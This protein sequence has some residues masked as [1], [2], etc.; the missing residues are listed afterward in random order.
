MINKE[1]SMVSAARIRDYQIKKAGSKKEAVAR[2]RAR[3]EVELEWRRAIRKVVDTYQ[4]AT[5][6]TIAALLGVNPSPQTP[7]DRT[8]L[9]QLYQRLERNAAHGRFCALYEYTVQEH[10]EEVPKPK[11]RSH[12]GQVFYV[13]LDLPRK[14][15]TQYEHKA[16][17]A[18]TRSTFDHA[19]K[20]DVFKTDTQIRDEANK[21]DLIYDF[22]GEVD[23]KA[24]ALECNLD[25]GPT[26]V[27]DKCLRWQK[28]HKE[29]LASKFTLTSYR[30]LWITTTKLRAR[31][32]RDKWA[33]EKLDG[34]FLV[35]WKDAFTPYRPSS[36]LDPIWFWAKDENLHSLQGE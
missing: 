8:R 27:L 28:D 32:I 31:N 35:T 18:H 12:A 26:E 25:D 17:I 5:A 21:G 29:F 23:N 9:R 6:S 3:K 36:F 24:Y 4:V 11:L 15:G 2:Q 10:G 20:F 34:N 1:V 13:S 14:E 30:Y 33:E 16:F 19:V 7:H 22:Y